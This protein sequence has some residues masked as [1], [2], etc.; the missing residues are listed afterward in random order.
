MVYFKLD[1]QYTSIMLL[2]LT[3]QDP[4]SRWLLVSMENKKLYKAL[5]LNAHCNA[6]W[7]LLGH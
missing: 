6:T 7:D 3:Y 4:A 5:E 2:L 1:W